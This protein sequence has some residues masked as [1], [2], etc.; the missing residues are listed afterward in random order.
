MAVQG[1]RATSG[2]VTMPSS[3]TRVGPVP[4]TTSWNAG[5]PLTAV[6]TCAITACSERGSYG[7]LLSSEFDLDG[8]PA[9]VGEGDD[10]VDLLVVRIAVVPDVAVETRGEDGQVMDDCALSNSVPRVWRSSRNWLGP[11]PRAAAARAGSTRWSFGDVRTLTRERSA[12]A[13]DPATRR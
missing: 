8:G 11:A 12:G 4:V 7:E 5:S 1:G 2:A 13:T 3:V 6:S 9:T 10:R